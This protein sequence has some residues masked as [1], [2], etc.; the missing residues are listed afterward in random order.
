MLWRMKIAGVATIT[1]GFLVATQAAFCADA[2]T[3]G[4]VVNGLRLGIGWDAREPSLTLRVAVQ[5]TGDKSMDVLIGHEIGKG[6]VYDVRFFATSPDGKERE[7]Y[8]LRSFTAV[9]GLILP[10]VIKLDPG[11][12]KEYAFVAKKI[13]AIERAADITLETLLAQGFSVRA[14]LEVVD[15]RQLGSGI[16]ERSWLGKVVSPALVSK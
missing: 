1:V 8:D 6:T 11:E 7:V 2:L 14:S 15:S 13:I 12:T 9:V 10:V 4:T 16:T 3:W 5:N